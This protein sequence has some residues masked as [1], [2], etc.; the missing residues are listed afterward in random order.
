MKRNNEFETPLQSLK[1]YLNKVKPISKLKINW[2][3][4]KERNSSHFSIFLQ[5]RKKYLLISDTIKKPSSSWLYFI[6]KEYLPQI[7]LLQRD[8]RELEKSQNLA[9]LITWSKLKLKNP[10]KDQY[11]EN[12]WR[13]KTQFQLLHR[14]K[15]ILVWCAT[16]K[17]GWKKVYSFDAKKEEINH[18]SSSKVLWPQKLN[19]MC[20]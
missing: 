12:I 17:V 11:G 16:A 18:L 13:R 6:Y 20:S 1:T 2:N 15:F 14:K 5:A 9:E 3:S 19:R 7:F 4:Q 8:R 10:P